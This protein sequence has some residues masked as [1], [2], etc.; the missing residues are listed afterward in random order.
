[1]KKTFEQE[2]NTYCT[3]HWWNCGS[4]TLQFKGQLKDLLKSQKVTFRISKRKDSDFQ[5]NYTFTNP[6]GITFKVV[7]MQQEFPHYAKQFLQ[8]E[9][10]RMGDK[11]TIYVNGAWRPTVTINH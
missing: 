3:L 7:G 4:K 9:M 1:M 8:M 10:C 2:L 6:F 5:Y 11:S